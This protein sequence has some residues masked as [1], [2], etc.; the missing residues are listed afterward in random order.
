VDVTYTFL[1]LKGTGQVH[2]ALS[3]VNEHTSANG[4]EAVGSRVII[5]SEAKRNTLHHRELNLGFPC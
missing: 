5:V 1:G 4:E 2:V 3:P